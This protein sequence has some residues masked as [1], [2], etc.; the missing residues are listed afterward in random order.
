[1]K[2]ND[3]FMIYHSDFL[4]RKERLCLESFA[5]KGYSGTAS[6]WQRATATQAV[7]P[8]HWCLLYYTVHPMICISGQELRDQFACLQLN[9]SL[10]EF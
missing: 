5:Q 7:Q 6:L 10:H 3:I 4:V 9:F 1:M 2:S 8:A